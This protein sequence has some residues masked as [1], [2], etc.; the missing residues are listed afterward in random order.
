[1]I[2]DTVQKQSGNLQEKPRKIGMITK[3]A[4]HTAAIG[5]K[6]VSNLLI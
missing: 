4:Y 6:S 5:T 1:M 2:Q 3:N